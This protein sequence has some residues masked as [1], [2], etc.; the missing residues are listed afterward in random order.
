M[1]GFDVVLRSA[2]F[3]TAMVVLLNAVLFFFV[4]TFP[5]EVW[6]ALDGVFAVLIGLLA[7]GNA[8]EYTRLNSEIKD[9]RVLLDATN[10]EITRIGRVK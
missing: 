6:A 3:W 9:Q 8:R 10:R 7:V 4:P 1:Y 5:K 2:P